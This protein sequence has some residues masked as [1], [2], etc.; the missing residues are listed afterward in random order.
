MKLWVGQMVSSFGSWLGAFPLLAILVLDVTPA[1]MGVLETLRAAPVLLVGLLAGVWIDR[2]RRRRILIAADI[3]RALLLGS[4]PVAALLGF[5]R[6]EQ[7]Y[8]VGF[9]NGIL[10]VFFDAGFQSYVPTLVQREH[11]VEA[12]SKLSASSSVAEIAAPPL[13]GV[14]VQLITA[15]WMVLL[16][17]ISFLASALF[18]SRIRSAE[19]APTCRE[20]RPGLWH[21]IIQ[22]LRLV[23]HNPTLLALASSVGT[24]NFFGAFFGTLYGL[25]A[26]RELGLEPAIVGV[27]VG[28]GGLGAL[29][30]TLLAGRI[31]RRYGLGSTLI[32]TSLSSAMLALLIPLAGGPR[33]V[34]VSLLMASQVLGDMML[35]VFSITELS[36][37]QAITPD[38][39]LGRVSASFHFL[40]G[41]MGMLGLLVGGILGEAMGLRPAVA[42]AAA[43]LPP[44]SLVLLFSPIR[45][46][47]QLPEPKG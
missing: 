38:H 31:T 36:L 13:G 12:N 16:D 1:Q 2:M 32:G 44:A 19:S 24:R 15:P 18:I 41:G 29:G 26:I 6:I 27:L 23:L 9:L 5:L 45:H 10:A 40:V 46:M 43:G 30:G 7:L 3:G 42:V 35:A 28:G 47:R 22:G 37:R 33:L 8:I 39:V 14:L 4:I 20:R 17:A 21:G 34:A 11:L 25:Y